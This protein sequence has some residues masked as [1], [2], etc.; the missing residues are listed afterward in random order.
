MRQSWRL[1]WQLSPH[2][3]RLSKINNRL[4][5]QNYLRDTAG[6]TWAQSSL[7]MQLRTGHT[8]LNRHLYRIKR[9]SSPL[10]PACSRAD[11]STHHY[12]FK[13]RAHKHVRHKLQR[14]LRRKSASIKELLGK[15]DSMLALLG[16]VAAT[17]HLKGTFGDVSPPPS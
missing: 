12:L 14:K 2:Y 9:A 11:E 15:P 1:W 13:C 8:P 5:S 3:A 17:E 16:Y 6:L 10:C 7:I 4:P